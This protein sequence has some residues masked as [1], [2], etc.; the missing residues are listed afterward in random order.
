M[1]ERKPPKKDGFPKEKKDRR[2]PPALCE[3]L[4]KAGLATDELLCC[5]TGDMDNDACYRDAWLAFDKKGFYTA[6]GK[7]EVKKSGNRTKALET[8]Y[9][10]DEII[11]VPVDE[12]DR[13]ELEQYVSTG[14]LIRNFNGEQ[15]S[16][17]RFS[18]GLAG[19][20]DGFRKAF[21]EFKETGEYTYHG[22][23]KE[24]PKC[25]KCGEPCPPGQEY[26]RKHNKSSATAVR[27]FKF[28]G[29]HWA[30]IAVI[31]LFMILQA[32]V[33][34]IVPQLSTRTLYDKVFANPDG[35][36]Q[37]QLLKM[38]GSLVLGIVG[39]RFLRVLFQVIE[40]WVTGSIMPRIM[41]NLKTKIFNAMQRLS[42]SFYSSKQ[43]GSLMD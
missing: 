23:D 13:F 8:E 40:N 24:P 11:A 15:T 31:L 17:T 2:F 21:D 27:L 18:I 29:G 16:V 12:I 19:D 26:C 28:F 14:R 20:F 34:V 5:C 1:P 36:A 37:A 41:F 7:A 10:V 32:A 39:I 22:D 9:T 33:S 42:L 30:Q 43:T 35:L 4:N 25:K 38:L 6:F 3:A